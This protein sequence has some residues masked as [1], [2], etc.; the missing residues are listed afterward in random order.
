QVR[1]RIEPGLWSRV[2][3]AHPFL[4]ALDADEREQLLAR[5]AWLLASKN[6]NGARGLDPDDFMRLSIGAQ[7]ALPILNLSPT[8][9]EGWDEIIVYPEGFSIRRVHQDDAGV[10]H[11]YDE[12]AAGEAWDGGP[13]ILSW[14]DALPR[15][16]AFNVVIHELAHKLDLASGHA[17][18]CGPPGPVAAHLAAHSGN[19]AGPLHRGA[20]CHRVRDSRPY[21]PREPRRRPLVWPVAA[22]PVRGHG[23]SRVF[24]G[25]F[26]TFFCGPRAA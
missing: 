14:A 5:A 6:L 16:G 1:D 3:Q 20:G 13:V 26:G 2:L 11:E 24:C 4:A 21:R 9:Y 10:V 17:V 12:A 23:R 25:Q 7:A 22:G 15:E 8:L 18:A 19:I